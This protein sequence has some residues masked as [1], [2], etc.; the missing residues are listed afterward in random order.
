MSEE[1][2]LRT[3][4]LTRFFG[5]FAAVEDLDLEVPRGAVLGL[6]GENGAGKTTAIKMVMG[7]LHPSRGSVEVFGCP[8]PADLTTEVKRRIGYVSET[9][10]HPP[11]MT[12]DALVRFHARFYPAWDRTAAERMMV[13]FRL[14]PAQRVGRLSKGQRRQVALVL[15]LSQGSDLLILDEPFSGLDVGNRREALA[16][17]VE[18][19]G[20]GGRTVLVSSHILTDLE[21]VASHIAIL[22]RGRLL[23]SAELESLQARTKRIH[24]YGDQAAREP[25]TAPGVEVLRKDRNGTFSVANWSPEVQGAIASLLGAPPEVEDLP[26]EE[27]FL[28][29]TGKGR[30]SPLFEGPR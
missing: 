23:V 27:I 1:I 15:A 11:W 7:F 18:S 9:S 6:L 22:N 26:L 8:N 13:R 17:L 5:S 21:R 16:M 24:L 10:M 30:Y 14:N 29:Y 4:R 25:W 3:R 20:E 2:P 12:I 28:E 19:A